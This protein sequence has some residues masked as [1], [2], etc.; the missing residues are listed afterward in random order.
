MKKIEGSTDK[1]YFN[2]EQLLDDLLSS[3]KAL[4]I[5]SGVAESITKKILKEVRLKITKQDMISEEKLNRC[6]SEVAQKY[7]PDLAYVYQNRGRII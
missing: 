5:P 2:E 6:I 7:N 1:I 4:K 3:A